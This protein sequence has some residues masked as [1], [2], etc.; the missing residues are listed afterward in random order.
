MSYIHTI[1]IDGG[2]QHLIEPKLFATAEG[3]SSAITASINNFELFPGAYVNIKVGTVSANATLSI[4]YGPNQNDYTEPKYIFYNN[5]KISAGI[6]TEG[7]IYTF[8]YTGINWEVLGDITGKNIMI[9]TTAEWRAISSYIPPR[10]TILIYSDH[11]TSNGKNVPGIKVADGLAY[12][13]DQPFVGD[14]IRDSILETLN[15]HINDQVR[16][17]TND[18]RTFWNSKINC[19]NTIAGEIL[20]F[21]RN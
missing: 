6:L 16:H 13:I 11:G 1:Q 18:E 20:I 9:G 10:G 15:N 14:D 21:K 17:I 19:E 2:T 5:V 12:G 7:N 8:I 3:T 4:I